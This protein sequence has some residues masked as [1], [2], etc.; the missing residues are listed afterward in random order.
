MPPSSVPA[1]RKTDFETV[2]AAYSCEQTK[3]VVS[4]HA[5]LSKLS[6]KAIVNAV[7]AARDVGDAAN[8]LI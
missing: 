3:T 5:G 7:K 2:D 1:R 8:L 4:A 6:N